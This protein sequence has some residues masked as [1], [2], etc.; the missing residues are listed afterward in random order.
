M[1]VSFYNGLA[2][3]MIAAK[4]NAAKT[5]TLPINQ[6]VFYPGDDILAQSGDHLQESAADWPQQIANASLAQTSTNAQ[7]RGEGNKSG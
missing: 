6:P 4:Q 7:N 2:L 5:T 1:R 3:A